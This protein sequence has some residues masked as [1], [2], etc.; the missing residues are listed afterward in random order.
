MKFNFWGGGVSSSDGIMQTCCYVTLQ[1]HLAPF[2]W[3]AVLNILKYLTVIDTTDDMLVAIFEHGKPFKH[4]AHQQ[5]T[6]PMLCWKC[7]ID[8]CH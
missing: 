8:Y 2:V 4:T 7:T 5:N 3:I 1:H 6:I